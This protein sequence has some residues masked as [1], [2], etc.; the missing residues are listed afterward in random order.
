VKVEG[1][2]TYDAPRDRVWAVLMNPEA[3]K[4]CIP[5]CESLTPNGE[6]S[7]EANLKV[8]VAAIRGS[9]KGNVKIIDKVEPSSY[10]MQVEGRGGAGFVRGIADIE[11]V[12]QG[13]STLVNVKGDGN[14]GGTVAGVGQRMLGGVAKMLM[15]QFFDCLKKQL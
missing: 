9:Y 8:G 13:G 2:F 3:L 5:G 15:G 12:D 4:S 14:V 1:S 11:L 6:D 7:F 10:K